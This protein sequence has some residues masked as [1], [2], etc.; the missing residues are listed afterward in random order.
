MGRLDGKAMVITGG[1]GEIGSFAGELFVEEGSK[2]LLV[3]LK[4]EA[5]EKAV[6][7]IGSDAVSYAVADVTQPEQV[8]A[9]VKTA[10]ERYGGIDV[11]LNNAGIEGPVHPLPAYE[12]DDFDKIIAVN[13]RGVF[14]GMKHVLPVMAEKGAGSIVISSSIAGVI[15]S[16][17]MVAYTASKHATIGIMRVAAIEVAPLGIRVNTINPGP[18]ESRMMHR[19]KERILKN[20]PDGRYATLEEIAKMMLFLASDESSHCTGGMYM[21]D[22]GTTCR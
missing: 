7:S 20:T 10:V 6:Q 15:G 11:F 22:G 2:V 8:E 18:V 16:P 13:V 14:L 12:V 19:S 5:L 4:K 9:Y 3:D 17:G 1:A 21:V